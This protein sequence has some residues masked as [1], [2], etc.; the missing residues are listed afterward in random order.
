MRL[1]HITTLKAGL[2]TLCIVFCILAQC[3]KGVLLLDLHCFSGDKQE[4]LKSVTPRRGAKVDLWGCAL[5]C[6]SSP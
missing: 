4:E 5:G 3:K 1:E 2:A 6:T